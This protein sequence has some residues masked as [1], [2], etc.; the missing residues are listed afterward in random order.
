MLR[1]RQPRGD[2]RLAIAKRPDSVPDSTPLCK[3]TFCSK[4]FT[5]PLEDMELM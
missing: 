2:Q 5:L 4:G 1:D 3:V